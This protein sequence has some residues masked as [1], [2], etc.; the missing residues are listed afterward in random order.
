MMKDV[1]LRTR[2]FDELKALGV[3]VAL[4]DFGTADTSLNYIQRFL[5]D[6]LKMDKSS[7]DALG[8]GGTRLDG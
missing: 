5:V 8:Q 7:T 2:R 1:D 6:I 3:R 4:D